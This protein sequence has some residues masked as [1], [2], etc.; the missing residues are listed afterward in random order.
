MLP[1]IYQMNSDLISNLD[2]IP[3]VV[4]SPRYLDYLV[5]YTPL[6]CTVLDYLLRLSIIFHKSLCFIQVMTPGGKLFK[7]HCTSLYPGKSQYIT[8]VCRVLVS[9]G[10]NDEFWWIKPI[11]SLSC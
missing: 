11:S 6:A 3:K 1:I 10:F 5:D 8:V 4:L 2:Y 9:V 7:P